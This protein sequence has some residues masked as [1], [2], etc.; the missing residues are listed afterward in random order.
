ML[1]QLVFVCSILCN[2]RLA[3]REMPRRPRTSTTT[4]RCW[5]TTVPAK[6]QGLAIISC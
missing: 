2:H 4:P 1:C 6:R 5:P 3:I